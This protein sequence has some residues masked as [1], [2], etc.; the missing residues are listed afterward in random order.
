[1]AAVENMGEF[2]PVM[3]RLKG[4][5]CVIV[6]GGKVGARKA[7]GLLDAG[8]VVYV[9]SPFL[10]PTLQNL[11]D[12][13]LVTARLEH[14]V[15]GTL[16]ELQPTLVFAATGDPAINQQVANEGRSLGAW[17]DLAHSGS[18]SDFFSM[19]SFQRGSITVAVSSGG[20]SS[21]LAVRLRGQ[22]EMAIGDEYTILAGWIAELKPHIHEKVSSQPRRS[23]LWKSIV[24]SS[25]LDDLRRGDAAGARALFE[26]MI[27]E[28]IEDS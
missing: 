6:G 18:D 16:A 4:R 25:I 3:L 14:Y 26:R 11:A 28:A 19:S 24:E 17:V 5:K 7:L 1:M 8:A 9:I 23:H 12:K 27:E 22:L 10:Y 21:S 2:Y 13:E 15:P 20:I